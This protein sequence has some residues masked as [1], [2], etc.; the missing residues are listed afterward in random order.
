MPLISH[1]RAVQYLLSINLVNLRF[2]D[3]FDLFYTNLYLW[4]GLKQQVI[5]CAKA[6]WMILNVFFA[7][8]WTNIHLLKLYANTAHTFHRQVAE[9]DWGFGFFRMVFIMPRKRPV[10]RECSCWFRMIRFNK[11]T[12][13]TTHLVNSST[14]KSLHICQI[15]QKFAKK[16]DAIDL[17]GFKLSMISSQY[18]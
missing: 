1:S 4:K 11:K 9:L 3:H 7:S 17:Q 8:C 14:L 13:L 18:P 10:S 6:L 16:N 12:T 5:R 2:T 15:P